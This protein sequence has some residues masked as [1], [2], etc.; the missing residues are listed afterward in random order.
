MRCCAFALPSPPQHPKLLLVVAENFN[1]RHESHPT[2]LESR[3]GYYYWSILGLAIPPS[4]Y[5]YQYS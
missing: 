5:L 2:A 3:F 4:R 1:A